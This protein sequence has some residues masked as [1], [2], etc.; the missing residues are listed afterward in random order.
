MT[1]LTT[2][3]TRNVS[4]GVLPGLMVAAKFIANAGGVAGI[5]AFFAD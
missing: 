3:E 1:E 2:V 5:I 4:G